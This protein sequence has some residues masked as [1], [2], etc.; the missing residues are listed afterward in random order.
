MN[1]EITYLSIYLM[2][3]FVCAFGIW[4]I[5]DKNIINQVI[6]L[7]SFAVGLGGIFAIFREDLIKELKQQSTR[8]DKQ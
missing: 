7:A 1:K 5:I 4:M 2:L 8:S 3:G 6:G